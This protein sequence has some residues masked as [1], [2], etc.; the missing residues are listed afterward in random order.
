MDDDE[1]LTPRY[2]DVFAA[3]N[4]EISDRSS[5]AARLLMSDDD[6]RL[7][8]EDDGDDVDSAGT[9]RSAHLWLEF[10]HAWTDALQMNT[11]LSVATV[12]QQR[13]SFGEDEH[14]VGTVYSDN[15]FRFL[16][17][18]QDWSWQVGDRHLPRWGFNVNRQEG[19]Y[20]YSLLGSIFDP[21]ITPVPIPIDY[22]TNM[23]VQVNKLGV[24][25]SWRTR[26]TDAL[27]AE[28][29][30][31]W[32]SY[33]YPDDL[34]FDVVSP[35]L[36]LVY[37]FGG[38]NELRAAWGV[39]HQPQAVNELQVED[40]VTEFFGPERSEQFVIGYARHF[41]RGISLRVDVYEKDYSDLR[42]RYENLLDPSQLIPEGSVGP[43]SHRC[44]RSPCARRRNHGAT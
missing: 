36:N 12:N 27:T 5:V 38:V 3:T 7:V 9:G 43:H 2:T 22:G 31:R 34:K 35:R 21:L 6:L 17:F 15:D 4:F 14:R 32:D 41:T 37:E 25:G 39:V 13:D 30:A 8:A 44:D 29:G 1:Q 19:D 26:I 11:I 33:E 23:D 20:D 40:N 28:A 16:D 24:Y 18:K 10:D 42:A